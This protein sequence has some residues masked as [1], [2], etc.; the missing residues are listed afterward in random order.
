MLRACQKTSWCLAP[1]GKTFGMFIFNNS[2]I[3]LLEAI[4][5]DADFHVRDLPDEDSSGHC[6][7]PIRRPDWTKQVR[8]KLLFWKINFVKEV[9]SQLKF[10]NIV[11]I[12]YVWRDELYNK[13]GDHHSIMNIQVD[14]DERSITFDTAY[15]LATF[16]FDPSI[17]VTLADIQ[18]TSKPGNFLSIVGGGG[19]DFENWL[20]DY[21]QRSKNSTE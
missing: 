16:V 10:E 4:I 3:D 13:P 17:R 6:V 8:K 2:N 14:L 21:D 20:R 15:L 11:R 19:F 18:Q 9:F 7:F 5:H 1:N 12:E